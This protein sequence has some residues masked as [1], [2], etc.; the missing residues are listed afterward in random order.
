MTPATT[1]VGGARWADPRVAAAGDR[2]RVVLLDIEGTV[3]PIRFVHDTLF[4]F[5]RATL[6]AFLA[7]RGEEPAVAA[8]LARVPGADKRA[9]LLDWMARDAKEEP[10]KTLQ[11]L[12]WAEGYR[13]GTLRGELY[14][15]VGPTLRAW[16]R[17]D[18]RLAV[19]SSG[20]EAAQRLIF[21]YSDAGDLVPLF[22]AF[23]DLRVGAKRERASYGAIASRLGDP[24]GSILFL[25]DVAA[26]LDAAR[27]AGMQTCQVVRPGDGT[28]AGTTHPV[29]ADLDA[30][31]RRFA[32]LPV[33]P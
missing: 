28:I 24:A 27:D 30:V 11:G 23:F 2:V 15:D 5:A 12:I 1:S 31:T 14:D 22:D 29:A 4:A 33:G 18:V 7:A 32:L 26:E 8:V 6:D 9:T 17:G 16:R 10:L 19:Y 3:A 13:D 20:S 21:G 25:S